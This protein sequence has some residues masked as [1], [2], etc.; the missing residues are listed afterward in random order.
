[1]CQRKQKNASCEELAVYESYYI[2]VKEHVNNWRLNELRLR[3]PIYLNN[4]KID[5]QPRRTITSQ[6]PQV[7]FR[8]T[9]GLKEK[10]V[11]E[12]VPNN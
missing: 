1:M 12:E 10:T 7:D 9:R 3:L 11:S 8:A 6:N 4:G 5:I 2:F